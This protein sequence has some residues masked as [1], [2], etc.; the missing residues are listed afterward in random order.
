MIPYRTPVEDAVDGFGRAVLPSGK[1]VTRL[2][3]VDGRTGLMARLDRISAIRALAALNLRLPSL[4]TVREIGRVG[5][6]VAPVTL[7]STAEDERQMRGEA[8]CRRHDALM[9][10]RLAAAGWNRLDVVSTFGKWHV[11]GAA[12]GANRIAGWPRS[13]GGPFIQQGVRDVHIGEELTDYATLT[14]GEEPAP[15]DADPPPPTERTM[16][17]TTVRLGSTGPDVVAWQR[18]VGVLADGSFGPRTR[19][20]T[21]VWQERHRLVADG[22]VGPKSWAAAGEAYVP[23]PPSSGIGPSP[24]CLAAIRDATA[25]WPQ[26]SRISDGIMGDARHVAAG[27]SSHNRGDAVDITH[28]P[29]HG[30][31]AGELARLALTDPRCIYVI[32]GRRIWNK[33]LGDDINGQGRPYG[34]SNPHTHHVHIDVDPARRGD[35][36]P[37]PWA[38]K[39]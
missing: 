10:E 27:T 22:I 5:F 19:E 11:H 13:K 23:P 4:E 3:L 34:G 8:F 15:D 33:A 35:D 31:D 12:P 9:F 30:V 14:M 38:P 7:V 2:P 36:R 21:I 18:I 17:R 6:W 24:A 37:W 16:A 1:V 20:A 26:R 28:D 39:P 29:S 32:F 25:R